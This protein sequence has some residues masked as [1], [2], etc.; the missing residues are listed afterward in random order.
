MEGARAHRVERS[1]RARSREGDGP[2]V[3]DLQRVL[4]SLGGGHG[5]ERAEEPVLRDAREGLAPVE[6][7]EEGG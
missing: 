7:D 2:V 4:E 1:P 6:G 3:V 5:A